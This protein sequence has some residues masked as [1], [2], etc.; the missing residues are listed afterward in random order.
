MSLA[1]AEPLAAVEG[2]VTVSRLNLT[3]E[4][5]LHGSRLQCT[6][7]NPV[8]LP[9]MATVPLAVNYPPQ[10]EIYIA[11]E[12]Q[13]DRILEGSDVNME[14][15]A[16][17]R[18]PPTRF[19]WI[20]DNLVISEESNLVLKGVSSK[21]S[22][23]YRCTVDNVEGRGESAPVRVS[24]LYR[25]TC[26]SALLVPHQVE[27]DQDTPG[28][29]LRCQ[30]DARPAASSYRWFF[31]SSG[32]SFEIPSAKPLMSFMNYAES[33][34]SERGEVLCWATNDVGIQSEPCVFH[35]VPLGSPHP[36]SDCAISDRT[37]G[38]VEVA[39]TPG[40]SGGLEQHF[41]LEVYEMINGSQ[42]LVASNWSRDA[43]V[44]VSGLE[45]NTSY[46][47][48]VHAAN[49]RGESP[50]VYVGGQTAS[51]LPHL[52]HA[53]LDRLPMLYIIVAVL[54]SV[55]LLSIVLSV[56]AACRRHWL[57]RRTK[58]LTQSG[59]ILSTYTDREQAEPLMEGRRTAEDGRRS[60]ERK[61]S[62][63][64]CS[65]NRSHHRLMNSSSNGALNGT[66]TDSRVLPIEK[67]IVR[68]Y[69]IGKCRYRVN[70]DNIQLLTG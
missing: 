43:V 7:S 4:Q 52:P 17:S 19:Q 25:P 33:G 31:N 54:L 56:T 44:R 32:G 37:L 12:V 61:V 70:S 65:C 2:G 39:C 21:E 35:V 1:G 45:A 30:V 47:L 5:S 28:V 67:T 22:G 66:R 6:A 14:C 59:P 64:E 51:S 13:P 60:V 69:S 11:T 55:M 36:P 53:S 10:V 24:V 26:S 63:R 9:V 49:E 48:A 8:F 15:K 46:I 23:T 3:L 41:V 16:S 27:S 18:P 42:A 57:D 58:Q 38:S 62:F 20:K 40:F 68:A 34:S 50:A 29:D